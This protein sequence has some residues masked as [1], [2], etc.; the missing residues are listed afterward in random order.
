MPRNM[1][2]ASCWPVLDH[3]SRT[4][5]TFVLL[6]ICADGSEDGTTLNTSSG[7]MPF[8]IG[9]E[10]SRTADASGALLEVGEW[11]VAVS[12]EPPVGPVLGACQ[13]SPRLPARDREY[14]LPYIG[15]YGRPLRLASR[16]T[17]A[18]PMPVHARRRRSRRQSPRNTP[19]ACT[20]LV[21]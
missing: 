14:R 2:S 19:P 17:R 16:A 6:I 3:S 4:T 7:S 15:G 5:F 10:P 8:R 13:V 20:C 18:E 1:P 11:L 9:H 21:S 12:A